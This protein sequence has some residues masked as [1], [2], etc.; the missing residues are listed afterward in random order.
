MKCR[1]HGHARPD[2]ETRRTVTPGG[3][4]KFLTSGVDQTG[5]TQFDDARGHADDLHPGPGGK[6]GL[7]KP[8]TR[9]PDFGLDPTAPKITRRLDLQRADGCGLGFYSIGMRHGE[10]GKGRPRVG[11]A[12]IF[13]V[14]IGGIMGLTP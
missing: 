7:F 5:R 8:A 10:N 13:T 6:A 4:W 14:S 3:S 11:K 2:G 12:P 1:A 9:E